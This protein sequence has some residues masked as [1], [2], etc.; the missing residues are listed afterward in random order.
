MLLTG[1]N[2]LVKGDTSRRTLLCTLDTHS[3]RP[4]L[5]GGFQHPDL[6]EW[7]RE[8]RGR[9]VTLALTV[10]RGFALAGR[11]ATVKPIGSF[12]VWSRLVAS[13]VVWAGGEDVTQAVIDPT[14]DDDPEKNGLRSLLASWH[15]ID[16][17]GQGLTTRAALDLLYPQG[18]A[19]TAPDA[20]SDLREAIEMLCRTPPGKAPDANRLGLKLRAG[21]GRV[22]DGQRFEAVSARAHSV[23]WVVVRVGA[24]ENTTLGALEPAPPPTPPTPAKLIHCPYCGGF[25][26]EN[27]GCGHCGRL[28]LTGNTSEETGT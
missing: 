25:L 7:I 2:V 28:D 5:R 4:E 21:K 13:A 14:T 3:E 17:S 6:K 15:T 10:L 27:E 8:N 16:L 19:P 26:D 12:E 22:F 23:R 24:P 18:R 9:L 20:H 1:I 11:P